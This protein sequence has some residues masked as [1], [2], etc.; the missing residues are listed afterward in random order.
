MRA[1]RSRIAAEVLV[2]GAGVAFLGLA[3]WLRI[4]W[5]RRRFSLERPFVFWLERGA[6]VAIAVALLVFVRPRVGAW[7]ERVGAKEAASAAARVA[8]AAVLAAIA[9][10]MGLRILGLPRRQLTGE[11]RTH[12]GE[13]DARY[14]W[15]F[16]A[17]QSFEVPI[18]G[19]TVRYDFNADHD[20]AHRADEVPD[21][22]APSVI[23]AGESVTAGHGLAW[24]ES[25]PAIVGEALHL[26]V[27]DLGQEG[28]GSDQVFLRLH[29]ALPRFEHPVAVVTAF[30]PLMIGRVER[31]DHPRLRFEGDA[32][33]LGPPDFLQTSH[34]AQALRES[35]GFHREWA[36]E[37]TRDVLRRT[38]E[39]AEARGARA[40]FVAPHL[41][42]YWPRT[43][44]YFVDELLTKQGFAVVNPRFGFEPIPGDTHPNA[45]STRRLAEAV[46]DALRRELGR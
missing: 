13:L 33:S 21:L 2:A 10:E 7:A 35:F 17:S 19:R 43:D 42:T 5:L 20:R 39:L 6:L 26:Q 4:D 31:D 1:A 34:L 16:K 36:L 37:E 46:V 29:D 24:D 9:S 12:L 8:V 25:L 3:W 22:R 14:G 30:L 41:Q 38:A 45:A 27:V 15:Q 28:Y 44:D 18:G 32:I 23:F 11:T 40:V